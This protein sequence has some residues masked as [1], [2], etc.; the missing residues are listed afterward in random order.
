ME[1]KKIVTCQTDDDQ[2]KPEGIALDKRVEGITEKT[3]EQEEVE[4]C[5]YIIK[6]KLLPCLSSNARVGRWV[7][8]RE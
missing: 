6:H 5:E 4:E 7:S 8:T 3:D 2:R 1:G